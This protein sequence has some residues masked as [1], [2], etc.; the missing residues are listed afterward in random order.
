M[1]YILAFSI[2]LSL[3]KSIYALSMLAPQY[4]NGGKPITQQATCMALTPKCMGNS[5][6]TRPSDFCYNCQYIDRPNWGFN[7][8]RPQQPW[9]YPYGNYQY[10]NFYRPGVWN[11]NG[12]SHHYY[13]GG[14]NMVAGKPNLYFHGLEKEI[15]F[16]IDFDKHSN[17]LASAPIHHD[18]GWMLSRKNKKLV[19]D[20]NAYDYLYY[21]YKLDSK[22]L[23]SSKGFCGSKRVVYKQMVS[24]LNQMKF[25][26]KEVKDFE[27]FWAVKLPKGNFCVYPQS[28]KELQPIAQWKSSV[29]PTYFKRILFVVV[30]EQIIGK[31][32]AANFKNRPKSD[33]NPLSGV[34]RHPASKN[35]LQ[36]HEWGVAFLA[37]N[38]KK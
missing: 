31:K 6:G 7:V 12:L 25:K 3:S 14:G 4:V 26:D 2:M 22:K 34:Y 28:H 11:N 37:T 23:Q 18:D 19:V 27:D 35:K 13:R 32:V 10:Q 17:M 21:D 30:P 20:G 5:A 9:W 1:K 16:V 15:R 38:N 24:T 33:W 8:V 36:I 29:A